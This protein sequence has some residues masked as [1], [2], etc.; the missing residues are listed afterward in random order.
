MNMIAN[1]NRDSTPEGPDYETVRQVIELI[2]ED[3]RDQ[4][5]LEAIA[6]R[7]NQSP[8]QLAEDLHPLGRAFAQGLPAGRHARS[9]QAAAAQGRSCRCLKPRSRSVLSG[10]SR[11]HDL[12]VTHEAMSPGEWKAKGGGLTIR[13]GFHAVALRRRAGHGHRS[14]PCRPVPS[15]DLGRREPPVSKT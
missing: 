15:A 2:T 14:R 7:L 11:L 5:S 12:F 6:A 13:Y 3:Y 4:P 1:L 8:T 10:P 9:C